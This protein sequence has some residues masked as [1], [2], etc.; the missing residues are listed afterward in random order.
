MNL[1]KAV[2]LDDMRKKEDGGKDVVDKL[3]DKEGEKRGNE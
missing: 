1:G 3:L 2:E